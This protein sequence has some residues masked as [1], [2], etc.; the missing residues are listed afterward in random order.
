MGKGNDR[1]RRIARSRQSRCQG[2]TQFDS[3]VDANRFLRLLME[4]E[5]LKALGMRAYRCPDCQTWHV[6]RGRTNGR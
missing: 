5:P 2:K 4:K 3:K 1:R 6:G